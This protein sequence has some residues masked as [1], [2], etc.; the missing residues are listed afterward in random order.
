M[1][2]EIK[3]MALICLTIGLCVSLIFIPNNAQAWGSILGLISLILGG[4]AIKAIA[5]H[6]LR[7]N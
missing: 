1:S 3:K 5:K 2:D 4:P 6:I 7:I